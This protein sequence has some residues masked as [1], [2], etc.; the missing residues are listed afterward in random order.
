MYMYIS[1]K[2]TIKVILQALWN[3]LQILNSVAVRDY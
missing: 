3:W 2:K 1:L